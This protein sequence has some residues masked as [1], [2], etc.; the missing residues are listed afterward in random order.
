MSTKIDKSQFDRVFL[1]AVAELKKRTPIDTG[2]LRESIKYMWVSENEF[3]IWVDVGDTGA[4]V[5]GQKFN[6]GLAPYTPFTNEQWISPRWNGKQNPNENWWNDAIE[7]VIHYIAERFK[8]V[9][10]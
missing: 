10:K 4:F 2:N 6:N 3:E 9:L 1:E 7:F 5:K 8:G